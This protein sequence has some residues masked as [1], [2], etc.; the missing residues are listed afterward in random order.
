MIDKDADSVYTAFAGAAHCWP[1]R[2]VLNVMP[3]TAK[4]YGIDA[5][6]LTYKDALA[7]VETSPEGLKKQ[8]TTPVCASHSC[9]K[10]DPCSF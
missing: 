9:S 1:D 7:Q 2:P 6:A 8:A 10:T 4:T 5:G 3:A